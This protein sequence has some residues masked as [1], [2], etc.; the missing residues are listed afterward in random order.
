M[1]GFSRERICYWV[2]KLG[3]EHNE[4]TKERIKRNRLEALALGKKN[5]Y[6]VKVIQ[7]IKRK[8]KIDEL[9]ILSGLPQ[10]TKLHFK[11]YPNN[12]YYQA[13]YRLISK[14]GYFQDEEVGGI[15]T[16]YY[17]ELT[18]RAPREHLFVK[19]YGL[20]FEKA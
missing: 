14:Y 19:R 7:A 8:R 20:K 2:K 18:K 11:K 3:L 13:I 6:R 12:N 4:A 17:D 16:L 1:T 15:Y 10:L 5:V 9:R